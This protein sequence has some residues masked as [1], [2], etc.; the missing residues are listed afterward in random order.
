MARRPEGN[1]LP[2]SLFLSLSLSHPSHFSM[3]K[4]KTL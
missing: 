4:Y 3:A 2:L 1:S